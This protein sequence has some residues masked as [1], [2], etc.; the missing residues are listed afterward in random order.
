MLKKDKN[1]MNAKRNTFSLL[2]EM[3]NI[4]GDGNSLHMK[5]GPSV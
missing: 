5:K 4:R 1:K 2:L 3:K